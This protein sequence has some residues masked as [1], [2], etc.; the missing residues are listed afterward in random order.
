[1][2]VNHGVLI[3]RLDRLLDESQELDNQDYDR[4]LSLDTSVSCPDLYTLDLPAFLV[5]AN[6]ALGTG[7][8]PQIAPSSCV[9]THSRMLPSVRSRIIR[10]VTRLQ[11]SV[12]R[13]FRAHPGRPP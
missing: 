3:Y 13:K 11:K 1:M 2:L 12:C 10:M 9:H 8:C 7:S 5:T 6:L 4:L